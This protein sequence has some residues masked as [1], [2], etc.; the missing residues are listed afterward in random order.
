[1]CVE[2]THFR[3]GARC[4]LCRPGWRLPG[5]RHRCYRGRRAPALVTGATAIFRRLARTSITSVAISEAVRTWLVDVAGFDP[6]RVHLKYNGVAP[7]GGQAQLPGPEA[8]TE[9]LFVGKLAEYKGVDLLLDAWRRVRHPHASLCIVGDGPMADRVARAAA[10]AGP[11]V[12]WGGHCRPPGWPTTWPQRGRWWCRR[13][14]TSRSGGWRPRRW[15]TAG[16]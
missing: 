13:C 12:R 3:D 5:I 11:R 10:E 16:R 15:R 7:P 8:G 4:T 14:G 6:D 2:G 9:F 1:M